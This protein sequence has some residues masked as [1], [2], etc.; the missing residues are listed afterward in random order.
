MYLLVLY[1]KCDEWK[2]EKKSREKERNFNKQ[3]FQFTNKIVTCH[4]FDALKTSETK[5][6]MIKAYIFT[7]NGIRTQTPD[8]ANV[9]IA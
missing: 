7:R 1:S 3:R 6:Q 5:T 2:R 4:D 8:D 9:V